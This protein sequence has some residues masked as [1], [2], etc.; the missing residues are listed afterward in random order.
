M[1]NFL[2]VLFISAF[3]LLA[4]CS[5]TSEQAIE[6]NDKII[7]QQTLIYNKI[8]DLNNTY[9]SYKPDEMDKAY[10]TALKQANSGISVV[11]SMAAFGS[12]T[13]FRDE[14]IKLFEL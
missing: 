3:V 9:K 12:S 6:Y 14:A 4:A 2:S 10:D 5:P 8:N 11:N 13:S 1:K 7:D